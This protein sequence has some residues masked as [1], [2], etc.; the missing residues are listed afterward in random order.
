VKCGR[1]FVYFVSKGTTFGTLEYNYSTNNAPV[2]RRQSKAL[3]A[4]RSSAQSCRLAAIDKHLN[5]AYLI[6]LLT[7]TSNASTA[8]YLRAEEKP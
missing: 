3:L 1:D 8:I 4:E 2:R 5:L 7:A 6:N